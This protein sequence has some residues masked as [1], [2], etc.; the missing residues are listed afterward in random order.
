MDTSPPHCPRRCAPAAAPALPVTQIARCSRH[1]PWH[2]GRLL[3]SWD[4]RARDQTGD[5]PFCSVHAGLLELANRWR[6]V[7]TCRCHPWPFRGSPG[8]GIGR[9][10]VRHQVRCSM[11]WQVGRNLP[12]KAAPSKAP[13]GPSYCGAASP[14]SWNARSRR[15]SCNGPPT[16]SFAAP[17]PRAPPKGILP[18]CAPFCRNGH[19]SFAP[20]GNVWHCGRHRSTGNTGAEGNRVPCVLRRSTPDIFSWPLALSNNH[21]RSGQ[22]RRFRLS[23]HN[24]GTSRQSAADSASPLP[25]SPSISASEDK[26]LRRIPL[27][28]EP[29][30]VA[31]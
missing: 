3:A 4:A 7:A 1:Y 31:A 16:N 27:S 6:L 21:R 18:H 2:F 24:T 25:S 22:P 9:G 11:P 10:R 15:N 28:R 30:S 12:S 20:W 8:R 23:R 5:E 29:L 17:L 14:C 19:T 13:T 26:L